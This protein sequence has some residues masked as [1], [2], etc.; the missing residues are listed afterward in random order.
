M[1]V[2][3]C[4]EQKL[5]LTGLRSILAHEPDIEVVSEARTAA[6][7]IE[8]ARTQRPEIVLLGVPLPNLDLVRV[9]RRIT[10][11]NAERAPQVIVMGSEKDEDDVL[12]ALRAGARGA[13]DRN[14]APGEL[15]RDLRAVAA[16]N[17]ALTPSMAGRLI[18]FAQRALPIAADPPAQVST[19]TD[20]EREVLALVA[21]GL[22]DTEIAGILWISKATVRS[23]MHHVLGKLGLPSR[24]H[25]VAFYYQQ[26]LMEYAFVRDCGSCQ[27]A[28]CGALLGAGQRQ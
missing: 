20:R 3:I 4:D 21:R 7:A 8:V 1:R 6:E 27:C 2:L 25:A 22:D 9:V 11:P 24:A 28:K 23:H 26:G 14:C 13:V 16:G 5:V 10:A 17:A 15:L 19:L 12:A 18:E